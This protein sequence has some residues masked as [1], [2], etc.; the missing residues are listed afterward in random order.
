MYLPRTNKTKQS[1]SP[2]MGNINSIMKCNR[3]N[4]IQE[5]R[6]LIYVAIEVELL[7]NQE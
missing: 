3:L 5:K 7:Q 1:M 4:I 6:I 2:K